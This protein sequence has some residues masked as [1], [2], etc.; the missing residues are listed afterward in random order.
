VGLWGACGREMAGRRWRG[1]GQGD[2]GGGGVTNMY[3]RREE[4]AKSG[5]KSVLLEDTVDQSKDSI[6]VRRENI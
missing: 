1:G 4:M 6:G 3:G 2:G 5:L